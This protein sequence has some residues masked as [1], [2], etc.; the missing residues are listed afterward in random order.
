MFAVEQVVRALLERGLLAGNLTKSGGF[1]AW[2]QQQPNLVVDRIRQE[3]QQLGH[4]P[5]IDDIAWFYLPT[6]SKVSRDGSP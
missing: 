4:D 1:S 5:T 2:D 3:W 6:D